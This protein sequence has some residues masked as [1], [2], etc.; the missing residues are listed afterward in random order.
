MNLDN[1]KKQAKLLV[2]WHRDGNYSV[3]GR[4]RSLPRYRNLTDVEALALKFPLSEA[5]EIIA[6]ETGYASWAE[7][8]TGIAA[9]PKR[10]KPVLSAPQ[11]TAAKPVI[12]V[13]NVRA[14]AAFFRDKLGFAIDFLH[15]EPPFYGSVSRGGACLHL[16]FVHEPVFKDGIR[17]K[18]QLLS[19][20]IN[21]DNVKGLFAEFKLA[22]VTFVHPL[23]KEPWGASAFIISDP[24]GNWICFAG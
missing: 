11:I 1:L 16:R 6:V 24:D 20:F 22:G 23:R 3:G 15:G 19:A 8:K 12:N 7:L 10:T 14:S 13:T 9:A 5:Q 21:V 4:I 2:R 17:D 18:E